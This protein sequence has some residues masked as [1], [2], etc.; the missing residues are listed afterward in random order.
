[1]ANAVFVQQRDGSHH[2]QVFTSFGLQGHQGLDHDLGDRELIQAGLLGQQPHHISLGHN[3]D[4]AVLIHH[5]HTAP[6][7]LSQ[8]LLVVV[9]RIGGFRNSTARSHL[10]HPMER[11]YHGCVR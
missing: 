10:T 3:P 1:M 8:H 4:R 9:F 11:R 7:S 6:P 5:Q 2:V